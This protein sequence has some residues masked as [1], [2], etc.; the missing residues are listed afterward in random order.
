MCAIV[1]GCVRALCVAKLLATC[2]AD[3]AYPV[4]LPGDSFH[5]LLCIKGMV[6]LVVF[7]T[8]PSFV[9]EAE[10]QMRVIV[11]HH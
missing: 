2:L 3:S 1:H 5:P 11:I 10:G 8:K 9:T 4:L 7:R 6:L